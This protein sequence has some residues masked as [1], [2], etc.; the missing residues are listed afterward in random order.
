[1]ESVYQS[2]IETNTPITEAA[3]LSF[4]SEITSSSS[5]S[6]TSQESVSLRQF[7]N[8]LLSGRYNFNL[9]FQR[10]NQWK[11]PAKRCWIIAL[12]KG[13]LVDPLSISKPPTGPKRGINGGNRARATVEYISNKFAVVFKY[14]GRNHHVWFSDIP[15]EFRAS[16]YHHVLP[17]DE[18][19]RLLDSTIHLNIR[20]NLSLNDEIEWYNNMNKNHSPH[21]P[22][23]ILNGIICGDVNNPFVIAM[24]KLFPSIKSKYNIPIDLADN[25]S[26]GTYLEDLSEV[27]IDV[28]NDD[29][30]RDDS[31]VSIANLTNLLANGD[32]YDKSG[33][34]G[35]CNLD[36]L[37]GNMDRVYQIFENYVP[38]EQMR[39]EFASRVKNKPTQ[40]RFWSAMYLLGP[41]FY[42]IAKQKPNVVQV[43]KTF[44]TECKAETIDNVYYK[45][46][47][48]AQLGGESN[49]IRYKRAWE[50]VE[51]Y[52]NQTLN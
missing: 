26:L 44:L 36:V 6:I 8:D 10:K 49:S 19:E 46:L 22:G 29:D 41:I 14:E 4:L 37:N 28:M 20:H 35:N 45:E 1:M 51:A 23:H 7:M 38:S 32:T 34:G 43:W 33:F 17:A 30:T 48:S 9:P 21:T 13:H 50:L 16:R 5:S 2:N 42:S 31:V 15:T 11:L 25:H 40:Q 47:A 18:R 12:M 52:V 3:L 24:L 27:P 39:E